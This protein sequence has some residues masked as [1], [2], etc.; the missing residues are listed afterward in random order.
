MSLTRA[1]SRG[2]NRKEDVMKI[3]RLV[4]GRHGGFLVTV[5]V[6]TALAAGTA[7]AASSS[8]TASST[9]T[10]V[11]LTSGA[12]H[13][14]TTGGTMTTVLT[15]TLPT[16]TNG[17][18]YVI[19]ANGDLVNFNQSDYTRCQI[20]VNGSQIAANSATVG[21][22]NQS[23]SV[24]AAGLV[25]P[26]SMSG[27]VAVPSTGGTAQLRCWHDST[28]GAAPYVDPNASMWAH[29]TNSLT[30]GTE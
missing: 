23:G 15:L 25:V 27:G 29:R 18:H 5:A 3:N 11:K 10:V 20:V 13:L 17:T 12:K 4:A 9:D 7:Y 22:P 8:V 21:D 2:V 24:G 16:S 30:L 19:S 14:S 6:V 28:N 1:T 26:F